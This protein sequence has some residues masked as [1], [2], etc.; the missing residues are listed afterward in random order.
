MS[1]PPRIVGR[2]STRNEMDATAL[3]VVDVQAD[4]MAEAYEA[5]AVI[6]RIA[7]LVDLSLIHI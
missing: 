2:M 6:G 7:N 5:L 3:L 4:V 1:E